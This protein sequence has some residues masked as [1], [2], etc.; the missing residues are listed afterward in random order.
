MGTNQK[1]E[2][3]SSLGRKIRGTFAFVQTEVK[4]RGLAVL[5]HSPLQ[6]PLS[7]HPRA[8][9]P[10]FLT[11]RSPVG[12]MLG[13][14]SVNIHTMSAVHGPTPLSCAGA[15]RPTMRKGGVISESQ[16]HKWP[17]RDLRCALLFDVSLQAYSWSRHLVRHKL[18]WGVGVWWCLGMP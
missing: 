7:R 11:P 3:G 2:G 4:R 16:P 10:T 13:F 8:P 1:M 9:K 14:P 15:N 17:H 6:N 18:G 5:T 12:K